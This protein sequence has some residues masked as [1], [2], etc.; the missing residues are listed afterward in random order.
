HDDDDNGGGTPV[1]AT[2]TE[3]AAGTP[4]GGAGTVEVSLLEYT[5]T[6]D[7]DS[8]TVGDITFNVSNLGGVVHEFVV[9]QTDLAAEDLPTAADGSFDEAGAG[10]EV[11]DEIEDIAVGDEPTLT[12]SLDAGNYLL[13]CNIVEETTA[14]SHF[15]EGMHTPFTV[16]E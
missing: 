15:A 12:V 4:P 8:A 5:V 7:A 6:P 10:V 11:V 1:V 3:P 2:A 14:I 9:V 16:T 13:L